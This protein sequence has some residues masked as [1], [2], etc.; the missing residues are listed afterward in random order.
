MRF[1]NNFK[2]TL[3][4]SALIG[5][6]M[7]IGHFVAGPTG[8]TFGLL[9]GGLGAVISYFFSD[10][11]AIAAMQA[12]E[13][14]RHEMP[15]LHDMVERLAAKAGLPKPRIYVCPQPAP[16]AFATGRNPQ[17]AA[18]AITA[19]MLR[20]FPQHEIEGVLAHEIAHIKHRDVLIST[21][22]AVLAGAISQIGYMFM[23]FG[24]SRDSGHSSP[25][26]AVGAL[27]MIILAPL[28]AL[29]IQAAISRQREYA[30]DS[31]GGELCGDPLKLASALARLQAGNERIPT[32]TNPAFHAMYIMEPLH[33][34]S[35]MNLF[36]THP[37][38]EQ[39]IALLREQAGVRT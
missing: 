26:G 30:A 39:R 4:L 18:V 13:V 2:T 23:F 29:L 32:D 21:I 38:T 36:S 24:S 6:C 22:A 11:I 8:V 28:A 7:V 14:E 17:N 27:L 20:G 33:G 12:Q 34:G 5:L 10:K 25:L 37:P 1:V 31:Y 9:F 35:L 15:W 3:L 19:G 16:N